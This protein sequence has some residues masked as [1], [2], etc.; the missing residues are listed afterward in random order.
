[1]IVPTI[2]LTE[3]LAQRNIEQSDIHARMSLHAFWLYSAW[4]Q[5][6]CNQISISKNT[7]KVEMQTVN[8]DYTRFFDTKSNVL[9][10]MI[11]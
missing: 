4:C 10:C 2:F 9:F 6:Q 8:I 3:L 5:R 11:S 7:L 1:M